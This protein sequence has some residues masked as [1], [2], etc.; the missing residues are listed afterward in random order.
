MMA[1]LLIGR[2]TWPSDK[3]AAVLH[4]STAALVQLEIGTV[5]TR[6]PLPQMSAIIQRPSLSECDRMLGMPPRYVGGLRQEEPPTR[7]NPASLSEWRHPEHREEPRPGIRSTSFRSACR[8][9]L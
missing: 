9:A 2:K 3:P 4:V 6:P 5:R 8:A 1:A 7:H